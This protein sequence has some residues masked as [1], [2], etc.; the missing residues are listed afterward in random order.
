MQ[1]LT[2]FFKNVKIGSIS[3]YTESNYKEKS[4]ESDDLCFSHIR[5]VS[6]FVYVRNTSINSNSLNKVESD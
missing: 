4:H 6:C 5:T 3:T 2:D 1:H